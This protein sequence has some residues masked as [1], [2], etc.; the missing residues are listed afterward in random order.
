M[1]ILAILETERLKLIPL[2][3]EN[4]QPDD[5]EKIERRLGLQLAS[6]ILGEQIDREIKA[7]MRTSLENIIRNKR[8]DQWFADWESV[9][10]ISKEENAIIGGFCMQRCPD[11]FG[12]VQI[13]YMIQPEYRN[14]GYMTEALK[15]GMSWVFQRPGVSALIAETTKSNL[16]SHRVLEKIGMKVYKETD[17]S[18]WWKIEKCV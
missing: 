10:I 5:H 12:E 2:D 14:S 7:A 18:L 15:G 3:F 1:P 11:G 8:E 13:G 17:R 16:P 9:L 4:I 6:M